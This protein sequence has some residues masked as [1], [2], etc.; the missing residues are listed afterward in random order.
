MSFS[1]GSH[2]SP[3]STRA[4]SASSLQIRPRHSPVGRT[5]SRRAMREACE[6][7]VREARDTLQRQN[8]ASVRRVLEEIID[9]EQLGSD[10]R[11]AAA[12]AA[13]C[14]GGGGGSS[15]C[16]GHAAAAERGRGGGGGGEDGMGGSS[17]PH[18]FAFYPSSPSEAGAE[19]GEEGHAGRDWD[20]EVNAALT[21][22]ERADLLAHLEAVLLEEEADF[23]VDQ[24]VKEEEEELAYLVGLNELE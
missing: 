3:S 4:A 14:G 7:R 13:S 18:C 2:H 11:H 16:L 6:A 12:A 22:E 9:D 23:Y 24:R 5:T 10:A 1:I 15:V 17:A 21:T 20:A 8:R 19:S